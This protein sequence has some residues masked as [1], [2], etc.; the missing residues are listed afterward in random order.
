MILRDFRQ[1]SVGIAVA[2]Y[3]K[4]RPEP[5]FS[6]RTLISVAWYKKPGLSRVFHWKIV[7]IAQALTRMSS[8]S[9]ST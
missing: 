3:E 8:G 2:R 9:R 1:M 5:G 7:W 6:Q 4:T